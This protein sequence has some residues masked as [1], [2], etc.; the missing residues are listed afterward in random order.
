MSDEARPKGLGLWHLRDRP[1]ELRVALRWMGEDR[2][3][4]ERSAWARWGRRSSSRATT[5]RCARTG[6]PAP[7]AASERG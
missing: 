1:E 2:R 6:C 3:A 5:P 4:E 7:P